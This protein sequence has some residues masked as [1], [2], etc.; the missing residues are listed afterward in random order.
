MICSGNRKKGAERR[1]CLFQSTL[2]MF[3]G[4]TDDE[5]MKISESRCLYFNEVPSE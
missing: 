3:L 4:M 1:Y 2:L 5:T